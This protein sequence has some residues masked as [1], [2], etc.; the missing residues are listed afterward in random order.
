[1]KATKN[2]IIKDWKNNISDIINEVVKYDFDRGTDSEILITERDQFN[3]RV[4][5][6]IWEAIDGCQ[7]VIYTYNAKQITEII[8]IYDIFD[9]WELTGERFNNWSECAFA[10]IYDMIQNEISID[11]LITKYFANKYIKQGT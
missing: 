6:L 3:E 1:M 4:N 8:N 2:E 11:E 7:D 10:N 9:E 5:E